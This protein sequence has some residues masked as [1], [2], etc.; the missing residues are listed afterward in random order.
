MSLCGRGFRC[1]L[2]TIA[3]VESINSSRRV[4]Q[5]LLAGEK[6]MAGRA[7]LDVQF[8]FACRTCFESLAACASHC[9]FIIFRMN[10]GFHF[11][12]HLIRSRINHLD[13]TTNHTSANYHASSAF[14]LMRARFDRLSRLARFSFTVYLI[15]NGSNRMLQVAG[16][17]CSTISLKHSIGVLA[18]MAKARAS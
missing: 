9:D 16:R 2:L 17:T 4:N 1:L 14:D 15:D 7:N 11:L 3:T 10:S 6:W 12:T 18:P 13:Q 5:L 8:A